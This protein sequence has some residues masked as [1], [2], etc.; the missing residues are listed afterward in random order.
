MRVD[1][2]ATS[3]LSS[4]LAPVKLIS[5]S[6]PSLIVTLMRSGRRFRL[7]LGCCNLPRSSRSRDVAIYAV[8]CQQRTN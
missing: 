5:T 8:A 6:E 7:L 4:R 3:S 1:V 2:Y